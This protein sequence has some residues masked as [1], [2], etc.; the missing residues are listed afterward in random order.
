MNIE[1]EKFVSFSALG[2][3]NNHPWKC[4]CV[5]VLIFSGS[6][7]AMFQLICHQLTL[8][9]ILLFPYQS[10]VFASFFLVYTFFG[11]SLFCDRKKNR[12]LWSRG[13][14]ASAF[15]GFNQNYSL[16]C[17]SRFC[18]FFVLEFQWRL[19]VFVI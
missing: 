12:K 10:S 13:K 8:T 17:F 4:V 1:A 2:L 6:G 3:H 15:D 9:G 19:K 16:Q 11:Y 7:W 5:C 18:S 14:M